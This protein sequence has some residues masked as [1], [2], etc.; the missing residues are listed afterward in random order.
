LAREL[1]ACGLVVERLYADVA[2][3]P[4]GPKHSEFAVVARKS[5]QTYAAGNERQ[6]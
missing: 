3:M 5:S 4:Y 1:A 6:P 2:G